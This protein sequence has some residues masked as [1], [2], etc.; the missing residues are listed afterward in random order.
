MTTRRPPQRRLSGPLGEEGYRD[1]KVR[2]LGLRTDPNPTSS[3]QPTVPAN[4]ANSAGAP[5]RSPAQV[6]SEDQ[7]GVGGSSDGQDEQSQIVLL[8]ETGEQPSLSSGLSDAPWLNSRRPGSLYSIIEHEEIL[9]LLL[10]L[11]SKPLKGLNRRAPKGRPGR[12]PVGPNCFHWKPQRFSR[13]A[14]WQSQ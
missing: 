11:P 10:L 5:P 8:P 6:S 9:L 12:L 2:N 1:G 3:R 13:V 7:S 4:T 14:A